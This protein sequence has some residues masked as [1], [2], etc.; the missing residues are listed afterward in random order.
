MEFQNYGVGIRLN[1]SVNTVMWYMTKLRVLV[2]NLIY[3]AL[4]CLSCT[5]LHSLQ[6]LTVVTVC[7]TALNQLITDSVVM[8]S[9]LGCRLRYW[10][11]A[12]S[13]VL[14]ISL[15]CKPTW[16]HQL[17]QIL[18]CCACMLLLVIGACHCLL[19]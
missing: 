4:I 14:G 11:S 8:D 1:H 19:I 2:G 16:K 3:W 10:G 18:D 12:S 17:Q 9:F 13:Q 15:S 7:Y 5:W 6:V